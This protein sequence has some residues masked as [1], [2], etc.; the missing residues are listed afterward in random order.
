MA[1]WD[2]VRPWAPG[3]GVRST[4]I[5]DVWAPS[6]QKYLCECGSARWRSTVNCEITW[7][8]SLGLSVLGKTGK[9]RLP[10]EPSLPILCNLPVKE[11]RG[12]WWHCTPQAIAWKCTH[13][14]LYTFTDI[15]GFVCITWIN[16]GLQTPTQNTSVP[17]AAYMHQMHRNHYCP[18]TSMFVWSL[19][20]GKASS[21]K[22]KGCPGGGLQKCLSAQKLGLLLLQGQF[23]ATDQAQLPVPSVPG[24]PTSSSG[25]TGTCI[26]IH[27][28][29]HIPY[30]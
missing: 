20:Q 27:N 21:S 19:S 18:P 1:S 17:V 11:R 15:S 26:H 28:P 6:T 10:K 5:T 29:A 7:N 16:L 2:R 23:P 9:L 4:V 13:W 30:N 22:D 12:W 8:Q 14:L 24:H 3:Q 25:F